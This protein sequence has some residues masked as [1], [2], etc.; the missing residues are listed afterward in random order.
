MFG[1]PEL[2]CTERTRSPSLSCEVFVAVMVPGLSDSWS[3][4]RVIRLLDV[5]GLNIHVFSL[6]KGIF[7]CLPCSSVRQKKEKHESLSLHEIHMK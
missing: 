5:V 2:S 1:A 3:V 6:V 7:L 4:G